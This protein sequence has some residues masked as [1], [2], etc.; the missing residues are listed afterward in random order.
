MST[1][2]RANGASRH[3]SGSIPLL[4]LP[5]RSRDRAGKQKALLRAALRLFSSTGYENTTTRQI[6][7]SAGCAEGLIHRYFDGKAGLLDALVDYHIDEELSEMRHLPCSTH[8]LSEEF[9]QLV[10]WE[11][12]YLWKN[13]SFLRVIISRGLLDPSVRNRIN[14]DIVSSRTRAVMQ[15]L[16]PHKPARRLS[17]EEFEMLAHCVSIFGLIFGFMRPVVLGQDRKQAQKMARNL[18]S[19]LVRSLGE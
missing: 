11:V 18:A 1:T 17:H 12:E 13:R 14:R 8:N 2:V 16:A 3:A 9:L 4:S 7:A 10:D 5:N 19:M 6:A 15:R